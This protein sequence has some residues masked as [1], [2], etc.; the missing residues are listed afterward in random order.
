METKNTVE[1]LKSQF[2]GEVIDAG[3]VAYDR[4]RRGFNGSIDKYPAYIIYCE[5]VGDLVLA[6]NFARES[7]LLT[8]LRSG[9]HNAGGLGVCDGGVVIDLSKMNKITV[10]AQD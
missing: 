5:N 1:L 8:A 6:L 4:A 10:D 2:A 7:G 9:G 3:S